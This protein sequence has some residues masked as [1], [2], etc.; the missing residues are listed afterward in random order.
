MHVDGNLIIETAYPVV[1]SRQKQCLDLEGVSMCYEK[2]IGVCEYNLIETL[3]DN[4]KST[5]LAMGE[6]EQ[7]LL[8]LQGVG[9]K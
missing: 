4:L 2:P 9:D 1:L 7:G 5:L 8:Q 6:I 3:S